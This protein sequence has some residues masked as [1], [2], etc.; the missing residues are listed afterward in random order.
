MK[1]AQALLN[2]GFRGEPTVP[3]GWRVTR[4]ST[5]LPVLVEDRGLSGVDAVVR[6]I[7]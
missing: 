4:H 2:L 3:L 6:F 1:N 7:T 5:N